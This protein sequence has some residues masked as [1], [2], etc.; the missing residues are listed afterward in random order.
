MKKIK[1][2]LLIIS[3]TLL[4][5]NITFSQ[6]V[7]D[8]SFDGKKMLKIETVSGDCIIEQINGNKIKVCLEYTLPDDCFKYI[9]NEHSDYL[10]IKEKFKKS[11]SCKGYSKWTIGVPKDIE[12]NF[13]SFSGNLYVSGTRSDLKASTISGNY[14]LEAMEG[15]LNIESVSGNIEIK[16]VNGSIS[17]NSVSGKIEVEKIDTNTEITTVSGNVVV[18][19]SKKGVNV[20]TTSGRITAQDI[21]DTIYMETASGD[22]LIQNSKGVLTLTSASGDIK[23]ENIQIANDS[24]FTTASGDID[25]ILSKS[26]EYNLTLSTA[27][28]NAV[29]DYNGNALNGYFE[30]S[31]HYNHGDIVSP[32]PFNEE[33]IIEKHDREFEIKSFTKGNALPKIL[34]KSSS[35]KA[36]LIK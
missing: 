33:K 7:I 22:I 17:L 29:L 4:L 27:S 5:N 12:M 14:N 28:G 23:S 8:K 32:V 21:A 2:I 25:V 35:G 13:N 9:F 18:M 11:T 30:F 20:C 1:L 34:L 31:V 36:K 24:K 26:S 16:N 6:K 10:E 15:V 3:L 19:N